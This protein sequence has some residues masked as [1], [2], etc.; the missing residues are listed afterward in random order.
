MV[1]A[2]EEQT[3]GIYCV[4]RQKNTST[5]AKEAINLICFSRRL[6]E[7]IFAIDKLVGSVVRIRIVSINS[8]GG[9]MFALAWQTP[10]H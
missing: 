6:Y 10:Y 1:A 3:D 2:E 8:T 9:T 4:A 5:L 7:S